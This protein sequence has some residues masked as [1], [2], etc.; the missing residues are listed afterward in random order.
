MPPAD[1]FRY[2]QAITDFADSHGISS[3]F[4]DTAAL[5][6]AYCSR[7]AFTKASAAANSRRLR[8][9]KEAESAA[10]AFTDSSL[11]YQP[12]LHCRIK[13]WLLAGEE[14][15]CRRRIDTLQYF[16]ASSLRLHVSR[17]PHRIS[18]PGEPATY[19]EFRRGFMI[20]IF[21]SFR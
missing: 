14:N 3:G 10:F 20:R 15:R 21:A 16:N 8:H 5:Q 12:Q 9:A 13:Y 7:P 1:C 18:Q 17:M 4:T 11:Y 19:G 6:P 2:R